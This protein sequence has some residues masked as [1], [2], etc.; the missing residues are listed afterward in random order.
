MFLKNIDFLE[1]ALNIKGVP[2]EKIL[3]ALY[4]Q[5]IPQGLGILMYEKKEMTE[6][7]AWWIINFRGDDNCFRAGENPRDMLRNELYFDYL[8]GRALKVD[9]SGDCFC[10][11]LYDQ[12]NGENS[13]KKALKGLIR[14]KAKI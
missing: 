4:N 2:K 11:R 6:Q 1:N 12:N 5:A 3:A 13:A 7:E 9:L 10:S 8:F 14:Q